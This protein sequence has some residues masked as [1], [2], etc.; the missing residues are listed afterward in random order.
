VRAPDEPTGLYREPAREPPRV[1]RYGPFV[2]S[3]AALAGTLVLALLSVVTYQSAELDSE[4][5]CW[6]AHGGEA[7][8][9]VRRSQLLAAPALTV[10]TT[11]VLRRAGSSGSSP[12]AG[13][14]I[15]VLEH[16]GITW[17]LP[18]NPP[19]RLSAFLDAPELLHVRDR[20]DTGTPPF[21][22]AMLLVLAAFFFPRTLIGL[23]PR[24][25]IVDRSARVLLVRR[26]W[27]AT[28]EVSIDEIARVRVETM[29]D[30]ALSRLRGA[31]VVIERV[32]SAIVPLADYARPFRSTHLRAAKALAK[33]LG[34][35][36][37]TAASAAL[38]SS[39]PFVD[40]VLAL[41][42]GAAAVAIGVCV[43]LAP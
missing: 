13:A 29:G 22:P 26:A 14:F 10:T 30:D 6:R 8:R 39:P 32:D 24:R 21:L 41:Q 43:W 5:E 28:L 36:V 25:L 15:D 40:G 27:G 2:P 34:V 7:P 38:R 1:V 19:G 11:A 16:D 9:C 31:R 12:P 42:L 23:V 37:T 20:G 4:V 3:P 35:D 17:M 18:N 33:A